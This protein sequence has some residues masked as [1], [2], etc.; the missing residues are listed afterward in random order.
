MSKLE[1]QLK[2]WRVPAPADGLAE[3]VA[4]NAMN[5]PHWYSVWREE[6]VRT[7]TEW[8]YG[9]IYKAAAIAACVLIGMS[10]SY[11]LTESA[12]QD[13]ELE[14]LAFIVGL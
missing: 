3:R 12:R 8:R 6:A 14:E 10:V 5:R 13:A 1:D 11:S 4:R 7:L 9:L 2:I